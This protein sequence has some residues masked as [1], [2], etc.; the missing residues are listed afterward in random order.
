MKACSG[1][2]HNFKNT[3]VSSEIVLPGKFPKLETAK[4]GAPGNSGPENI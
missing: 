3:L 1:G 2:E 4:F